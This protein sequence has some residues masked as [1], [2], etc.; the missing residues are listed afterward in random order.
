MFIK[1]QPAAEA[2]KNIAQTYS[3]L[4]Q[5]FIAQDEPFPLK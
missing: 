1:T 4:K 3:V 5:F 2:L